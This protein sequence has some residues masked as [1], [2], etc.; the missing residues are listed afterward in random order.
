MLV[1]DSEALVAMTLAICGHSN[2]PNPLPSEKEK[3]WPLFH[4]HIQSL[5]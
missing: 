4:S 1:A 3:V 2:D 5:V